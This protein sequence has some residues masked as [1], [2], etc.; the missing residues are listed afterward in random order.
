MTCQ[1]VQYILNNWCIKTRI[2]GDSQILIPP[3]LKSA[4]FTCIKSETT[5][6]N[7]LCIVFPNFV[8]RRIENDEDDEKSG[9]DNSL[10]L[11]AM[12]MLNV[13]ECGIQLGILAKNWD[14]GSSLQGYYPI[15]R[16]KSQ[17]RSKRN[18]GYALLNNAMEQMK[19]WMWWLSMQSRPPLRRKW[20]GGCVVR[21]AWRRDVLDLMKWKK[22]A[23]RISP[24]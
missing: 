19:D 8:F 15:Q 11:H 7:S 20:C 13:R 12:W 4:T 18:E 21:S 2:N 5:Y 17:T 24:L 6:L 23:K 16:I 14:K 22:Q 1:K 9:I 10:H 3:P